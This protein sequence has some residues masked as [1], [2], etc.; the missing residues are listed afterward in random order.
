MFYTS[1]A[2]ESIVLM[3]NPKG[4]LPLDLSKYKS[5]AVIGP[6]ADNTLCS[7]GKHIYTHT[8]P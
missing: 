5:V 4:I 6:C 8:Y 7:Q 3:E 2:K 1:K